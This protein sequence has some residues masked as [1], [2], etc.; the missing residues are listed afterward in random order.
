MTVVVCRRSEQRRRGENRIPGLGVGMQMARVACQLEAPGFSVL[1]PLR[2]QTRHA[3]FDP[4]R[5]LIF[6]SG[7]DDPV[8][9]IRPL[10]LCAMSQSSIHSTALPAHSKNRPTARPSPA[11]ATLYDWDL[12]SGP[13]SSS[14]FPRKEPHHHRLC[15]CRTESHSTFSS[16]L[17]SHHV[18]Q[19]GC[20]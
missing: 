10:G 5:D 2:A 14:P 1:A 20:G 15:R 19:G 13:P 8:C 17:A 3:A 11:A 12:Q 9:R 18:R 16:S 4:R 6:R 7:R